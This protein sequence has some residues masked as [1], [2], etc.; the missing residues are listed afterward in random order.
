MLLGFGRMRSFL[1][2]AC[3]TLAVRLSHVAQGNDGLLAPDLLPHQAIDHYVDTRLQ[4]QGVSPAPQ[5]DDA[6][7]LRRTMLDLVGRPPTAAD[8]KA[9]LASSDEGK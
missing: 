4:R 2:I 8:A 7:L 5:A 9:Y 1:L 6:N 3:C